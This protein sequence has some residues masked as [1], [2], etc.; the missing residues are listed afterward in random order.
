MSKSQTVNKKTGTPSK[1]KQSE[2]RNAEFE[3]MSQRQN[4]SGKGRQQNG[5]DGTGVKG[6]GS[7][8]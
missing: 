7:N 1:A 8:H 4:R 3:T 6:R 5:S 2:K